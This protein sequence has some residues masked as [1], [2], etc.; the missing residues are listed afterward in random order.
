MDFESYARRFLA[1]FGVRTPCAKIIEEAIELND[2]IINSDGLEA[3]VSELADVRN[4]YDQLEVY[5]ADRA[6]LSVSEVDALVV[7]ERIRKNERTQNR[8]ESGY[9]DKITPDRHEYIDIGML[10]MGDRDMLKNMVETCR[11]KR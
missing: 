5:V 4:I 9:Y 2:S 6:N 7:E 11:R 3:C 8:I 1:H 10:S